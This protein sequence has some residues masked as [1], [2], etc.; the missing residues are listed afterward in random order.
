M[1]CRLQAVSKIHVPIYPCL[2][3]EGGEIVRAYDRHSNEN[4]TLSK[5]VNKYKNMRKWMVEFL[6]K[7]ESRGYKI[8]RVNSFRITKSIDIL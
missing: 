5:H 4:V 2:I 1:L 6:R 7:S 3:S 8:A